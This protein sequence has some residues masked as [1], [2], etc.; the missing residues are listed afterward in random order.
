MKNRAILNKCVFTCVFTVFLLFVLSGNI[1]AEVNLNVDGTMTRSFTLDPGGKTR[2][3]IVVQNQGDE[4]S[5][6][7]VYLQD[8]LHYADGRNL[9]QKPGAVGRSNASWIALTP[10]Q[11]VIP[12]KGSLTI[13]FTLSVPPDPK[14]KGTYWSLLMIEP[15]PKSLLT[16]GKPENDVNIQV[17]TVVRLAVQMISTVGKSGEAKLRFQSRSLAR[18]Q[19]RRLLTLDLENMGDRLLTPHV[20]TELYNKKGQSSGKIDGSRHRIYPGCSARFVLDLSK[21]APG[22][23]KAVVV[24]DNGDD[25]VF[26]ANYTLELK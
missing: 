8:Y 11:A 17:V 3:E 2:G 19:G 25:N 21:L 9:F 16:P 6:V 1:F 4:E 15:V 7:K 14:L 20:W 12:A 5:E 26:G 24:A 18:E 22:G 13:N 23:Y 10:N